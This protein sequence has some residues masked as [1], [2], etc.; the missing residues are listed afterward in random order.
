MSEAWW[1]HLFNDPIRDNP[2][3]IVALCVLI[4][5]G[6]VALYALG[7]AGRRIMRFGRRREMDDRERADETIVRARQDGE[8]PSP[9]PRTLA[10]VA[11]GLTVEGSTRAEDGPLAGRGPW[12]APRTD[13]EEQPRRF[14]AQ[15]VSAP[16]APAEVDRIAR[17]AP[18]ALPADHA[19]RDRGDEVH[20]TSTRM[21]AADVRAQ[22]PE[23]PACHG[24][25]YVM[26]TSDLLRESIGLVGDNGDL[27]VRE[28]YASLLDAA[29]NLAPLFPPD[30][31]TAASG[32][33]LSAGYG[34]RSRLLGALV[35]LSQTYDPDD[36]NA[37]TALD[38]A[39]SAWGGRHGAF[40][41]PDGTVSGASLEEYAAVK[42]VLFR[43]LVLAAGDLWRDEYTRAW[44]EAY[45][46]AAGV[47][48]AAQRRSGASFPRQPRA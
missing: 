9:R 35:S 42:G 4:W 8:R 16:P 12:S 38:T 21:Q 11:P 13:D 36:S 33:E 28:F 24:K 37:M 47:M 22:R 30:L 1:W 25:G 31:L 3:S 2:W 6:L 15:P 29:P 34:Q 32:D 26:S 46:Y 18:V 41:R 44:S 40:Q 45:D 23:C 43:V 10:D 19:E 48:L 17:M 14:L 39:L 5:L 20:D 7:V 27:L